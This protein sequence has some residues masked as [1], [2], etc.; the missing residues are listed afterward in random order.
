[1]NGTANVDALLAQIDQAVSD[2]IWSAIQRERDH[3]DRK[4]GTLQQR[5]LSIGDYLV[6]LRQELAEAERAYVG[7]LHPTQEALR[8]ILQVA[9]VAVACLDAHGVV[10]R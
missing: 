4:Y 1:M 2:A 6:I 8:E 7:Q 5:K 3:Q 10:E 9:A